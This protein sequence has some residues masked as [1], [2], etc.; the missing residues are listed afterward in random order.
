MATQWFVSIK[1]KGKKS[2]NQ[3]KKKS[4]LKQGK[5]SKE[6]E[7]EG[8]RA[9]GRKIPCWIFGVGLSTRGVSRYVKELENNWKGCPYQAAAPKISSSAKLT[10]LRRKKITVRGAIRERRQFF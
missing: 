4:L 9:P 5:K 6:K 1:K 3:N 7:K 2:E 10:S 8:A